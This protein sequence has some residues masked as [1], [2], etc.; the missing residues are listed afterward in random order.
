MAE[1]LPSREAWQAYL[2]FQ[3]QIADFAQ[4]IGIDL[5]A[6]QI[7]HV[8]MRVNT[9]KEALA[10]RDALLE[11]GQVLSQNQVNGRPIYLIKLHQPLSFLGKEVDV[12]E[13][14]FPKKNDTVIGWEHIEIVVPFLLGESIEAWCDRIFR[15]FALADRP[16]LHIKFSQPKASGEQKPNPTIAVRFANRNLNPYCIKIHPYPIEEIVAGKFALHF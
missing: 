3:T 16:T 5:R 15:Q 10:W 9:E 8:A 12:I 11:N 14:P 2:N 7:D 6:W 13:L 1:F 4:Q